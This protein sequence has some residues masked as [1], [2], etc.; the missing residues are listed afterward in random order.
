MSIL[1]L[2]LFT[3]LLT[4]LTG[5]LTTPILPPPNGEDFSRQVVIGNSVY[6]HFPK[7]LTRQQRAMLTSATA[8]QLYAFE[9]DM[10]IVSRPVHVWF[11]RGNGKSIRCGNLEGDFW[12]C[13]FGPRGPI[14]VFIDDLYTSISFYHELVHH[15]VSKDAN[16]H[17]DP[18]WEAD[19]E[20]KQRELR[21]NLQWRH[22]NIIRRS[23]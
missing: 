10:G 14:H 15:N 16:R 6:L 8:V 20:P 18:R 9:T 5:C 21:A 19:W 12:G 4:L 3:Y 11:S 23:E 22:R 2:L 13:H 17:D 7:D 1:R